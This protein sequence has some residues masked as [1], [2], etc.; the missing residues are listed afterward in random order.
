MKIG[1]TKK[2]GDF[3]ADHIGQEIP[4]IHLHQ[5]GSGKANGFCASLS[6]RI[7]DL[8][9]QGMDITC[10]KETTVGGQINSHYT[11]NAIKEIK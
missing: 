10:R 2:I 11:L 9:E 3:L 5:M 1:Q 8:R 4:A 6:R 7:S